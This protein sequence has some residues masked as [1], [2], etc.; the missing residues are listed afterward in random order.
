M[1]KEILETIELLSNRTVETFKLLNNRIE[2]NGLE[3]IKIYERLDNMENIMPEI[4]GFRLK[5]EHIDMV[6]KSLELAKYDKDTTE[7]EY[8]MMNDIQKEIE[9]Y[10][11]DGE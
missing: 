1:T 3:V 9:K 5:N 8:C 2:K 4:K 10:T 7:D 6:H 11:F